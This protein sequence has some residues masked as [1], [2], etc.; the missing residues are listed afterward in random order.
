MFSCPQMPK[1]V[2]HD[3]YFCHQRSKNE[4]GNRWKFHSY[5]NENLKHLSKTDI[6]Y[7]K[8]S[9]EH[10]KFRQVHFYYSLTFNPIITVYYISCK[11]YFYITHYMFLSLYQ[12][13]NNYK[14]QKSIQSLM[15]QRGYFRLETRGESNYDLFKTTEKS[16]YLHH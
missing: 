1:I 5:P 11:T 12:K 10:V 8:E 7:L 9:L 4:N 13:L 3:D 6:I 14:K 2:F 15:V 16:T